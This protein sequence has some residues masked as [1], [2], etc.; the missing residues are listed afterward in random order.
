[1][2]QRM[3]IYSRRVLLVAVVALMACPLLAQDA[4]VPRTRTFP[5]TASPAFPYA[6]P[7]EVGLSI[8]PLHRLGDEITGWVASGE[9]VGAELLVIKN[10]KAVFH[11]A[12][13]WSDREAGQPMERNSI[14]SIKSMSKPFTAA[15][16]LLLVEDGQLALDDPVSHYVPGFI[17]DRVTIHHLLSQTS[18]FTHDGDWYDYEAPE[19][20]LQELVEEW[21][22]RT[23]EKPLGTF[24]Y[25]DFN[26]ATLGYIV[27]KV[28]EMPIDTFTEERI[29]RALDLED[30]STGFSSAP[31]WR[32]RLNPWY[33]W[34]EQ[35]GAYDLRWTSDW[36]GWTFYPAGWGLF[37]TAM[38]YA[39]F[40]AMWMN[41]GEWE[42]MRL[43]SEETVDMALRPQGR[44]DEYSAY[45]YGWFIDDIAGDEH[46]PFYHGGGDGT[47]A[48][49]FP[50]DKAMVIYLTH[51]RSGSHRTALWNRLG[52]SGL[53]SHPGPSLTGGSMVWA[54]EG[55]MPKVSLSPEERAWYL[56]T[57]ATEHQGNETPEVLRVWEEAGH[58]HL[59]V[60]RAG[61]KADRRFHLVPLGGDRFAIG[62]YQDERLKGMDPIYGVRFVM[63]DGMAS[64]LE[65]IEEDR[66]LFSARRI[67]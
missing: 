59:R 31:A 21:P 7:E 49:A 3:P 53:F 37:S 65:V 14:F 57:Y 4:A 62:R 67:P 58:L 50:A 22:H 61:A 8:A 13:G 2:L 23:P 16:A 63:K 47:T 54:D 48:M 24:D 11:E 17:S 36:P 30:T 25:A 39:E 66:I 5:G 35:T 60:G 18:G 34:N 6:P 40:M 1:M 46:R 12:Y 45:G 28:S 9:L 55:T 56:G 29:I 15:A 64:T 42:R 19:A 44:I 38:D 41:G 32:A 26:W 51:S 27:G 10:E 33:R 52:M 20:S 43:L